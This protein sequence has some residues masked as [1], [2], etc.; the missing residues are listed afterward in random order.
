MNSLL[1]SRSNGLNVSPKLAEEMNIQTL[2]DL[3]S[4]IED[5][6]RILHDLDFFKDHRSFY[7]SCSGNSA[8][9]SHLILRLLS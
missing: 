7:F 8:A 1:V 4:M 5:H 2:E 9:V 3:L 6:D